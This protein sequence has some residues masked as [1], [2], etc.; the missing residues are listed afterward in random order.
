MTL[1]AALLTAVVSLTT[2]LVALFYLYVRQRDTD[3]GKY[4]MLTAQMIPLLTE[5][6]SVATDMNALVRRLLV[7]LPGGPE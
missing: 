2:A 6:K 3:D 7:R 5:L 4:Q 1:E